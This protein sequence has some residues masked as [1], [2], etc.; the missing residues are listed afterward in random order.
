M[1]LQKRSGGVAASRRDFPGIRSPGHAEQQA[2]H[3]IAP[4]QPAEL[5]GKFGRRAD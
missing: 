3:Q 4:Q 2:D 5:F 1:K